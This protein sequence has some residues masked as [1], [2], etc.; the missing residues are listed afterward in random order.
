MPQDDAPSLP[1]TSRHGPVDAYPARPS[2]SRLIGR[3]IRVTQVVHDFEGGGL[4]TLVAEMVRKFDSRRVTTS[5]VS[6]SGRVGRLGDELKGRLDHMLAVQ[7]LPTVSMLFPLATR[8][9]LLQ[10]HADVVHV[11]SGVWF[12]T[13]LAAR[14]AGVPS[15]VFTEHGREH[16]DPGVVRFLDRQAAR[17]T[18]TVVAVST[19]LENYLHDRVGIPRK[20]LTTIENGVDTDRFQPR[21]DSRAA[22]VAFGIPPT[23]LVVG[24]VGRLEP[25]KAYD[26]VI[27]AI[28]IGLERGILS[29]APH[30]L[31]CGDGSER[32]HL[33]ELARSLGLHDRVRFPGWVADPVDAYAAMDVFVLPSRSEGLSVSLLEAMA[34]GAVPLV[35]PVGANNE[36]LRELAS[37]VV[38]AEDPAHFAA[39]LAANLQSGERRQELSS[40]ARQI[41]VARYSQSRM[42]ESY[43]SLYE[44]LARHASGT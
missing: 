27:R 8:R 25:V 10:T 7:S 22:R 44:R 14:F 5:V 18:N 4:E 17:M 11:H 36:V 20:Q 38:Q 6:M 37:Q 43:T 2:E 12:K 33:Q 28:A 40:T 16:H 9:A 32:Q 29:E 19:R 21:V 41:V 23:G 30:L 26:R 13:A 24:S 39:A 3:P 1:A 34:S 35:T 31:L 42:L 15:V